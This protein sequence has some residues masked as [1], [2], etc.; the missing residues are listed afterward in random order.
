MKKVYFATLGCKVNQYDTEALRA[1]FHRL[2]FESA[3]QVGE[4][5]V[6]VVNTCSVT[7]ESDRKCRNLIRR[8]RHRNPEAFLVAAGCYAQG[9]PEQLEAMPEVDRVIGARRHETLPFEILEALGLCC[10]DEQ[11][12]SALAAGSTLTTFTEHTR[13][14]VKIEDGCN[15]MCTYCRIPFYRGRARSRPAEEILR[16]IRQLSE[17]GYREVVLCGIQLGAFGRDSGESLPQLLRDIDSIPSVARLRLSSIEPD[18]VTD[19]LVETLT[20]LAKVAPHLHLPLQSGDDGVLRRMRRGYTFEDYRRRAARLREAGGEEFAIST[21]VMVAFPGEDEAAF[22]R[23]VE[24]IRELEFCRLHIFRFSPRPGTRAAGFPD[25]LSKEVVDQRRA[26]IG[27]VAEEV[28]NKV[29]R[30]QIG[31]VLTVLLEEPGKEPKT[32][33]GFSENY[34][35]VQ[36]CM[37]RGDKDS[38]E[39]F[40]GQLVP[41]KINSLSGEYLLGTAQ[42]PAHTLE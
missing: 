8:L 35:R 26:E 3:R 1:A 15:Q 5:D 20:S 10:P 22:Q 29:R 17:R 24:A 28:V 18:D 31:R 11:A 39:R 34:L 14:F 33:V 4:A 38:I 2:G 19:E 25:Q 37:G 21:D 9:S 13:A 7:A 12:T 40:L 16:E 23:S 6:C 42:V 32:A 41:V 27:R 30:R 36:A